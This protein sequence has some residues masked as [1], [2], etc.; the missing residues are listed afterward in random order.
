MLANEANGRVQIE[1]ELVIAA[2]CAIRNSVDGRARRGVFQP[3]R[4]DSSV[5]AAS[6]RV[7]I[8]DAAAR[9]N[10]TFLSTPVDVSGAF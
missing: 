3:R 10:L 2:P 8:T 1:G 4:Q 7:Q 9:Q 5:R 6:P